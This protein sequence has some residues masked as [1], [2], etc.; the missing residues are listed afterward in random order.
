MVVVLKHH[1]LEPTKRGDGHKLWLNRTY[2]HSLRLMKGL[3]CWVKLLQMLKA[4]SD[5]G[6]D[7][8]SCIAVVLAANKMLVFECPEFFEESF[9]A[10]DQQLLVLQ[11]LP[12]FTMGSHVWTA[13]FSSAVMEL[14]IR[15]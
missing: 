10:A 6:T 11:L 2:A 15:A 9:R 7:S 5:P 14:M 4:F 3:S 1:V 12:N 13:G 8:S